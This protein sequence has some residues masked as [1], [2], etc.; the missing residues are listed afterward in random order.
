MIARYRPRKGAVAGDGARSHESS[1]APH[2]DIA[3]RPPT[4]TLRPACVEDADTLTT[5][6][7]AAKRHWRYP[8]EWIALWRDELTVDADAI[9]RLTMHCAVVA[10]RIVGFYAITC[11]G[12]DCELEHLWVLPDYMGQGIGAM[13]FGHAVITMS[14]RGGKRLRIV[15]DPAAEGFYLR[16]GARRVGDV[17]S[18]PEGRRLPLLIYARSGTVIRRASRR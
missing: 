1:P 15:T 11:A 14:A 16:Q 5:I 4:L 13:L 3:A 7:H 8:E 6:A 2:P 17:A 9:E 12:S 10:G 18:R